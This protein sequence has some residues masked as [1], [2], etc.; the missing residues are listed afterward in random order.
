MKL[1]YKS[2][3]YG[4]NFEVVNE[5]YTSKICSK[6]GY[7]NDEMNLNVRSWICP[8]CGSNHDRDVNAA[9][10]IRTVGTTGVNNILDIFNN[11]HGKTNIS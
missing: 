11:A 10:N 9:I 2:K 3:W 7:E 6:C 4:K 8:D 1:K 5:S